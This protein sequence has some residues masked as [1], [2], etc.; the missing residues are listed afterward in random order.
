MSEKFKDFNRATAIAVLTVALFA[1]VVSYTHIR[2]LAIL[3]HNAGWIAWLIPL[4][5]DGPI[6]ASS[7]LLLYAHRK[8]LST[9][10]W[11]RLTLWV[12]I[13]A[14][15][16]ANVAYGLPSVSWVWLGAVIAA[17]PALALVLVVES[18]LEVW[19]MERAKTKRDTA[20]PHV[21]SVAEGMKTV[22]EVRAE[23]ERERLAR[24]MSGDVGDLVPKA[25]ADEINS[26][27]PETEPLPV[28]VFKV[29]GIMKIRKAVHCGPKKAKE[30]QGIM[31]FD[32]CDLGTAT[33]RW[34][35]GVR[36]E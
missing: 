16:A 21:R 6:V 14:T 13:G 10:H 4:S 24:M 25:L 33:E 30:L 29:P 28:A 11:A 15:L 17:W 27:P 7:L 36:R 1:A 20:N 8:K 22:N 34:E 32:S 12:S 5:V 18:V 26:N 35:L 23:F 31:R 2:D 3:H 19:K 9:P